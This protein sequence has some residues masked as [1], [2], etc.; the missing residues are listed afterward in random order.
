MARVWAMARAGDFWRVESE[1]LEG[2]KCGA[3]RA[4]ARLT[5]RGQEG[6]NGFLRGKGGLPNSLPP[7]PRFL[8][9]RKSQT[10]TFST[11]S[12]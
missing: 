12:V 6:E 10:G 9:L 2:E 5:A 4:R 7:F 1:R 11:L 3:L 8:G